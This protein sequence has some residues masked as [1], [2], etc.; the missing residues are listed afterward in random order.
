MVDESIDIDGI[1]VLEV[2]WVKEGG[3]FERR[4]NFDEILSFT[5][6]TLKLIS[7]NCY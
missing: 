4:H 6:V 5:V 2:S 3:G 7:N 1:M